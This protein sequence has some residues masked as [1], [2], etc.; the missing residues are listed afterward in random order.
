MNIAIIDKYPMLRL[1]VTNM[2]ST[3][4]PQAVFVE[5]DSVESIQQAAF[6]EDFDLIIL[7]V[8]QQP[9]SEDIAVLKKLKKL[10]PLSHVIVYDEKADLVMVSQYFRAG[11]QGYISKQADPAELIGC[12]Q[13]VMARQRYVAAEIVDLTL[14]QYGASSSGRSKIMLSPRENQIATFLCEGMSTSAI[15]RALDRKASTISTIK[16]NIFQKMHVDNVIKL[17]ERFLPSQSELRTR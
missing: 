8:G 16:F 10:Y 13:Q 6:T 5:Q 11:I 12:I 7:G 1:G 17:R 14:K 9:A 3:H 15:A 4:F 2:L